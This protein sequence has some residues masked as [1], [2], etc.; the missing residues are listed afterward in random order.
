MIPPPQV[1]RRFHEELDLVQAR[2]MEMAGLAEDLVE[3][4]VAAFLHR[5]QGAV[6]AIKDADRRIDTLEVAL[7]ERVVE[8]IALHQPMASDLRQLLTTLKIS[9]DIERIGD[10][11]VNISESARRLAGHPPL[12]E[13]PELAE[14][15]VLSQRMLRDSLA[16][17]ATRNSQMARE[18]CTRDDRVDDLRKTV[19]RLLVDLMEDE[20]GRITA[21]QEYIR[22][23]QQ[24]ERIGDLSTNISEDVVFFVEGRTIKHHAEHRTGE[25]V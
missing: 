24:L 6:T 4:A 22:V 9:N 2:L 17:Y 19:Y 5:D 15:A 25:A 16:S 13:V 1:R 14:L 7:D 18:I 12:P 10:H 23:A 11:A 3:R 20:P 8:L 21:A